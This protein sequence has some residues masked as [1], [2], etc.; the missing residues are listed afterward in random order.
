MKNWKTTLIGIIGMIYLVA[1]LIL[2]GF[3]RFTLTEFSS[4]LTFVGVFL[5]ALLGFFSKD[6]DV[7]GGTRQQ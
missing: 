7:T 6:S 5:G 4:S 3:K 1:G 2:V